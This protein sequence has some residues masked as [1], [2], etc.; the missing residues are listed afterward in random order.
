MGRFII[1]Y[2]QR[3]LPLTLIHSTRASKNIFYYS[4]SN[5]GVY[6]RGGKRKQNAFISMILWGILIYFKIKQCQ[7]KL[8]LT[9]ICAEVLLP[10]VKIF[11]YC[12]CFPY[13]F[14][15]ASLFVIKAFSVSLLK[16]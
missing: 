8:R 13:L 7:A 12:L 16:S 9:A 14:S 5:L 6:G 2:G 1:M 3:D 11:K 15:S 4:H 10:T